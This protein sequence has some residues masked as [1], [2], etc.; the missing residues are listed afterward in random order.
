MQVFDIEINFLEQLANLSAKGF[1][2]R[3]AKVLV[4]GFM[5][6]SLMQQDGFFE[7]LELF[8]PKGYR[9]GC[10]TVEKPELPCKYFSDVELI[11]SKRRLY[12]LVLNG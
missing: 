8:N 10:S 6:F 4:K 2:C 7:F 1:I 3:L 5:N 12:W 11:L 9:P